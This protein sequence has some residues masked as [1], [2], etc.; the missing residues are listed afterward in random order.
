MD[1]EYLLISIKWSFP[2]KVAEVN[3]KFL[4]FVV[5]MSF[6]GKR[7]ADCRKSVDLL[8]KHTIPTT[9]PFPIFALPHV[10]HM[11]S[12]MVKTTTGDAGVDAE[13]LGIKMF[14]PLAKPYGQHLIRG[15]WRRKEDGHHG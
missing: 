5:I 6:W 15:L 13:K 9:S 10:D 11:A 2:R 12:P 3:L 1:L 7:L 8:P 4:N 14:L